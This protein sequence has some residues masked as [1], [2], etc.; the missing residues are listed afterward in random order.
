MSNV[1]ELDFSRGGAVARA[2]SSAWLLILIWPLWSFFSAA[3][4]LG[5]VLWVVAGVGL[6][7]TCW[8]SIV[9]RMFGP[10][11]MTPRPWAL[12]GLLGSVLALFPVLGV[13][14]AYVSFVFVVTA[15]ATA[16]DGLAFGVGLVVTIA[17][18]VGA[19]VAFGEPIAQIWWVPLIIVV[20]AVAVQS[21]KHMGGLLHRLNIAREEVAQ[22]AVDNER[23]RFARDLHD[24]LGHTL[25]SITIR[26]Q[27]AARLVHTDPERAAG[28]MGDVERAAR[29]AL[30]EVRQA[31]AGYRAPSLSEELDKASRSLGLAGIRLE[32]TPAQEP[33]PAETEVVLAWVVRE[34]ATNVLR[35]GAGARRCWVRLWV[36]GI[37]VRD[38]GNGVADG[39]A[40][41]GG[42]S[43]ADQGD[44]HDAGGEPASRAGQGLTAHGPGTGLQG[45]AERVAS[46]GGRLE[47][48][49]PPEGGYRLRVWIPETEAP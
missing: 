37:E 29:Q 44:G 39:H 2:G 5:R 17:V 33:I 15:L 7:A 10:G 13:P 8:I 14:W 3:P 30:D 28:E 4:G 18:E 22:L 26:S 12:A 35:H 25:S 23:L 20:Q 31:V 9:R 43:T 16:A 6:F 40:G 21:M 11:S 38:D 49:A 41:S 48:G 19:L 1:M 32:V 47:V 34:G 36:D 24:T 27:L 46:A 45:L 42:A